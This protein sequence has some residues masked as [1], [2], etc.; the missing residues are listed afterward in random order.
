MS[1]QTNASLSSHA[2]LPPP[3][4]T[5]PG[6]GAPQ[7]AHIQILKQTFFIRCREYKIVHGNFDISLG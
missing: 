7:Y 6:A 1:I 4:P 5:P 2:P 3:H